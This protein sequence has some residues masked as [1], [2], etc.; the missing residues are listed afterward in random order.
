MITVSAPGKLMLFGEHAVVYDRPCLATAVDQRMFVSIDKLEEKTLELE[1]LDVEVIGYKKPLEDLGK[2]DIP[3]GARFIEAVLKRLIAKHPIKGGL[4]VET[5]SEFSST[6]GFGS[7]SASTVCLV[8]AFSE[9]FGTGFSKKQ[10]FD[11]AYGAVLDVQG[12]GS[13]Y[14]V[15]AATYGGTIYFM[16]GGETIEPIEV[17]GLPLV[18]G[19]SGVKVDTVQLIDEVAERAKNY[20]EVVAR[21]YDGIAGVVELAK[22]RLM[23]HDWTSL[24]ELMNINEGYLSSLGVEGTKLA[25]MIYAAR[26]A[27]AYGAKLSGAGIGDCMIALVPKDKK[28]D[29]AE[30]IEGAGGEVVDLSVHVEG[31]RVEK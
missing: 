2:G 23:S 5:R 11:F 7:S 17:D 9:V 31:V 18:V 27:G 8:K 24:G 13:G 26:E 20:P 14:D 16:T 10:I 29:V 30:A 15:A 25:T 3:K 28:Q 21:I 19:Y 1:A 22:E 6:Y 4:R 12:K